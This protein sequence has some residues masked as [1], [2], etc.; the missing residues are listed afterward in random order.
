[1]TSISSSWDGTITS[2]QFHNAASTFSEIWNNFD[3]GFPHWSWINFPNKPGFAAT[4]VYLSAFF[5][6]ISTI[7]LFHIYKYSFF[8]SA[9][10]R[11]FIIGE[12]DSS[13]NN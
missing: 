11:I 1:M 10:T 3:L 5:L 4:K 2:T 13:H 8:F 9:A 6:S 12:Y 7:F